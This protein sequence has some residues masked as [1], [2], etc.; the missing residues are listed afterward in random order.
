MLMVLLKD[1]LF[2]TTTVY[3][4]PDILLRIH[5]TVCLFFLNLNL[6][7]SIASVS[8][9]LILFHVFTKPEGK[10]GGLVFVHVGLLTLGRVYVPACLP[11]FQ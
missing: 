5:V 4:S 11:P 7:F 1:R 9:L 6:S 8:S 2:S 3:E 10:E